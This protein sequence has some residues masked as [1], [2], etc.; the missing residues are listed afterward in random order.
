MRIESNNR[1]SRRGLAL[2]A[3]MLL[4]AGC[5]LAHRHGSVAAGLKYEA[6]GQYRAAYIEA[7]KVLQRDSKNGEAWLLLGRASLMLGDT[8]DALNDLQNAQANGVPEAQ[9]AVPMGRT[10]LVMSQFDKVLQT[11]SPDK[12]SEPATKAQVEIL[13]GDAERGLKQPDKAKQSYEAALKLQPKDPLALVGLSKLASMA[14]DQGAARRYLEQALAAAP[15]NPQAWVEKADLAY[16]DGDFT[17]AESDYT[18]VLGFKHA[19]WLPQESFYARARLAD[20]QA[21]QRQYGKALENIETLEK[22]AP[23]QPYPHYLHAVVLYQQGHLD[24]AV[25]QLQRVLQASPDSSQAQMLMG[26][27]NYAQGN[28]A[29]AEMY[30]GNV[31]GVDPQNTAAR[32]LLALAYYRAGR[33]GQA[34]NTLRPAVQGNPSDAELLALLQRAAAEGAGM[35]GQP[36]A[37]A[38]ASTKLHGKTAGSATGDD[39]LPTGPFAPAAQ[40]LAKGDTAEAIKLLKSTPAS[41][42]TA[43][44]QRTSLLVMAYVQEKHTAD[45][46]KT[47]A[48]F[49]AKNP[50]DSGAH[51]LYGTALVAAGD[52]DKA[53]AQYEESYKLDPKNLAA[54]LSLGS[55]DSLER[56]YKD[57]EGR[58]E[59]VLKQDP[60]NAVAITALGKL[61]V[62]QGNK[63]EAIQRFKQAIAAAP[64]AGPAYVDLVMLYSESGQF[65]EAAGVAKQLADAEPDNPAA[66]NAFGAA[67]LNAGRHADALKPLEQAVKLAPQVPLYRINLARAQVLNKDS[68]DARANL[69]TVI[70]AD[71]GE[72]QAVSLL[73]FMK[74]QDHDLPGAVALARTLQ[75]RSAD[76]VA[77][78]TLEGDLYMADK[79]WDKAAQVYQQGLKLQYD[80]PLVIKNFLA[81]SNGGAKEPDRVLRDWLAKHPDDG[82]TRLLLAQ[83]YLE[84]KQNTLAAG[85]YEQVLKAFPSNVDAL[86]NLAWIY[87]EQKSPKALA[88]A[89]RA[90]KLAPTSPGVMDTYGWA[91]IAAN[92]PRTA[93]PILAEAAK[94][95]PKVPAIQYHLAVAQARTGD[96]AGARAT[97]EA[98]EKSGA[99]FENKP[100]AEKLYQELGGGAS[101]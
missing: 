65:D 67:Q 75:A 54:L 62:L 48:D 13:R 25:E 6:N 4:L 2:L 68:K 53:R 39:A 49:A 24:G 61:A 89:E 81:L 19:D 100:A 63:A 52:R 14:N 83:Y 3:C 31:M 26:A 58:Y 60:N 42:A 35:P 12:V 18:K 79:S 101:K 28:Y 76:K 34:L 9:W 95:A 82:A 98:L 8:K 64:K 93:L 72:V 40:A 88:L 23:D 87:T 22:M 7:K 43:E 77:G 57:A 17:T 99:S 92:Q 5:G 20:A 78:L 47:A 32:K 45:A 38:I 91:L 29:Q 74:L 94:A 36:G 16:A 56:H 30:L 69:E 71:P 37:S 84:H 70:K 86:N 96:K 50:K 73:A 59:A 10:L 11:L 90:H 80:R 85:Q 41:G 66:L 97:L 15:E 44:T 21:R 1:V 51:L 33:S 46:V 55:L 27:V